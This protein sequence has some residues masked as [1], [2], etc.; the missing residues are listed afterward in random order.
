MSTPSSANSVDLIDLVEGVKA[1]DRLA[2][3]EF[4]RRLYPV[5]EIWLSRMIYERHYS[6]KQ[7]LMMDIRQDVSLKILEK[8]EQFKGETTAS[9]V[10]WC[11]Q[12]TFA[13]CMNKLKKYVRVQH[14][15]ESSDILPDLEASPN[16]SP[17]AKL[18]SRE[19][20]RK[21]RDAVK[22]MNNKRRREAIWLFYFENLSQKEI[23]DLMGSSEGSVSQLVYM[24]K[25][26][27]N[28]I[29]EQKGFTLC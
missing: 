6:V 2:S 8:L 1:Y 4:F 26:D 19:E 5:I 17:R 23:A 27:L 15:E 20:T 21:V 7:E 25:K 22:S 28:V 10:A 12:V 16:P 3:E 9:I 18:I 24:G 11:R 13:V 29:C 14:T